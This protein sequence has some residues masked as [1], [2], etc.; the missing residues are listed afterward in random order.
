VVLGGAFVFE[1]GSL[2]VALRAV[3]EARGNAP[4]RQFGR[5]NRDPTV[6]TAVLED[7]AA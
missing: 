7:S 3:R 5:D 4:L 1:T 6:T 2:V